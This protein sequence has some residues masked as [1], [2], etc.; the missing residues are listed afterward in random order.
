MRTEEIG[1]LQNTRHSCKLCK[2]MQVSPR[3]TVHLINPSHVS[4]GT[5][6]IT[7]R[8]LYVLAAATPKSS[9]D[10]ILVDETLSPLDPT[11]INAGDIVGIGIHTATALRGYEIGKIARARGAYV[12]FGGI[13]ATLYP[14]EAF[15][16]GAA[17][18]VVTGD[19]DR[20]WT[21]VV[22]DCGNAAPKRTYA[23]GRVE[24]SEFVAARWDLVP[25]DRYMWASVQTV[26]CCP[27]HCSF[28]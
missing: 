16:L 9:G 23:G 20:V 4:F 26:C 2:P 27:K 8:W 12:I 1:S 19:G 22:A 28:C 25:R 17:H 15:E 11:R 14:E 6:V 7:P 5:A 13:H 24:G 18:S 3:N 21:D 10:P